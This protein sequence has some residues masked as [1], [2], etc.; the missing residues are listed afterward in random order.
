MTSVIQH[1]PPPPRPRRKLLTEGN[2]ETRFFSGAVSG[3]DQQP[4]RRVRAE[5]RCAG[6]RHRCSQ[7]TPALRGLGGPG[8]LAKALP[9][10]TNCSDI[11]SVA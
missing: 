1:P 10:T 7:R 9:P 2:F 11:Q 8:C 5:P 6:P 3:R 4:E